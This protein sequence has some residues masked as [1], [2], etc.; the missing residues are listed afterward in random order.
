LQW[1]W[2]IF[3]TNILKLL[4]KLYHTVLQCNSKFSQ[5]VFVFL[6]RF[7]NFRVFFYTLELSVKWYPICFPLLSP[8]HAIVTLYCIFTVYSPHFNHFIPSFEQTE[9]SDN[10]GITLL[11]K[12]YHA[13]FNDKIVCKSKTW[14]FTGRTIALRAKVMW[15]NLGI[16]LEV[17]A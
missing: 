9:C 1:Q 15:S 11:D 4:F 5:F 6:E 10:R 7:W 14:L 13:K 17:R 16:E 3:V 2:R 8:P 12:K